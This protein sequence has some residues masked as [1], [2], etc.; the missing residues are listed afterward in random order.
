MLIHLKLCRI[1]RQNLVSLA[2]KAALVL[3]TPAVR[4][5]VVILVVVVDTL[6]VVAGVAFPGLVGAR[7]MCPMCVPVA[8]W[9]I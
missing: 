1:V 8:S 4:R 2:S 9:Y 5:V 3:P 6:V 7:Y